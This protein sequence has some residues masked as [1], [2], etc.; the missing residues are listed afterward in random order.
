MNP[1]RWRKMTWLILI[2][3]VLMIAWAASAFGTADAA[4]AAIGSTFLFGIWF[5][6]FIIL[7]IIWFM[8]RPAR[9]YCP[10]CGREV[11]KGQTTCKK[12]GYDF[13]SATTGAAIAR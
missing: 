5:I 2:F 1:L 3:T 13:A 12:C 8:T 6:G 10:A 9:R 4:T 7:S 11:K